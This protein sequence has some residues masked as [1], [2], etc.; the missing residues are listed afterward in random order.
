MSEADNPD[1]PINKLDITPG[2]NQSIHSG[3][4][5]KSKEDK[6]HPNDKCQYCKECKHIGSSRCTDTAENL[7][8]PVID[9]FSI[10][11]VRLQH[12]FNLEDEDMEKSFK[13][14]AKQMEEKVFRYE[15]ML[16]FWFAIY[17]EAFGAANKLYGMDKIIPDIMR[18]FRTDEAKRKIEEMR[19]V[20]KDKKKRLQMSQTSNDISQSMVAED[21]SK[22]VFEE[23]AV[24]QNK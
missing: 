9:L 18:N 21:K 22:E 3:P 10:Q 24:D 11:N 7:N 17:V 20:G 1:L 19:D 12:I 8:R 23:D 15:V 14:Q 4:S 5:K 13:D 2:S 16:A 6:F